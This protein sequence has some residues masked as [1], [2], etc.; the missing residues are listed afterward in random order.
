M[1][2][3]TEHKVRAQQRT[4]A[5]Q[6]ADTGQESIAV[7]QVH[8]AAP[9]FSGLALR[10]FGIQPKLVVGHVNDPAEAEADRVASEVV[11]TVHGPAGPAVAHLAHPPARRPAAE[12]VVPE[13]GVAGGTI[14]DDLQ[15]AITSARRGT[16]A[17]PSPVRRDMETA[18][19]TDLSAVR[20]HSGPAVAGLATRMSARAFTIG[21]EMF[22]PNGLPDTTSPAGTHLL[23]HELA[24]A[25]GNSP[26]PLSTLARDGSIDGSVIRRNPES[27]S[28]L[29][30]LATP[31]TKPGPEIALQRELVDRLEAG[32]AKLSKD[33]NKALKKLREW[34]AGLESKQK[35]QSGSEYEARG[36][37]IDASLPELDSTGFY[38]GSIVLH[39]IPPKDR[40]AEIYET[41]LVPTDNSMGKGVV[42]MELVKRSKTE[43]QIVR[44]TLA[45]M[46][47]AGQIDYLRKAG[48]V[49]KVWK[50]VVEVHYIRHR[51]LSPAS[52]HKD[53]RGQTLFVNLNYTNK[54]K[55]AG[56][57]Y[58]LNP[59][60][61]EEHEQTIMDNLPREFMNDLS[62]VRDRTG[63]PKIIRNGTIKPYGVVSFV[64]EAIHHATPL[65]GH[66][67]VTTEKVREYLANEPPFQS[68]YRRALDAWDK[69]K[70]SSAALKK[71][72]A[73]P[74]RLQ[75]AQQEVLELFAGLFDSAQDQNR[76]G[77]LLALTDVAEQQLERP[78]LKRAG[79]RETEVD[80]LLSLY[81]PEGFTSAS[82]PAAARKGG[83]ERAELAKGGR[84]LV[85][86]REMSQQALSG[87]LPPLTPKGNQAKT[88]TPVEG[89]A[90]VK[91]APPLEA[92][93]LRAFFRT[94]VRA[95]RVPPPEQDTATPK[96]IQVQDAAAPR[97]DRG[98]NAP[99]IK[100]IK[101]PRK[102]STDADPDRQS[103][104][105]V[106]NMLKVS[107]S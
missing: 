17:L 23:A 56:P 107:D 78:A 5:E 47:S 85:L 79:L 42:S 90:P 59:P 70:L 31:I 18:L 29:A 4:V 12:A 72:A 8:T 6:P 95:V 3:V 41:G 92:P 98:D 105:E 19:G 82:I 24:H 16:S 25:V 81:G 2:R 96:M 26:A 102:R 93:P 45:T 7:P 55:M 46:I 38:L 71:A 62:Y 11:A 104:V 75:Q 67:Q 21:S 65:I 48:F 54:K 94:W 10:A 64:D 43:K 63:D 27:Q 60:L 103:P 66:R 89:P 97:P 58:V 73:S 101:K 74:V 86:K 61:H 44:N 91:V 49:G 9:P 15:G 1:A 14:S 53:T 87:K 50:I 28:A 37:A 36:N 30:D 35:A 22:F 88:E 68:E 100:P 99:R 13:V 40:E 20:V 77:T 52:F 32:I 69:A 34:W 106:K 83:P 80:E 57:E 76:W 51:E 39:G 33:R 84:R